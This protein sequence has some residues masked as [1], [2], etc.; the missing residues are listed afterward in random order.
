M[1]AARG[2]LSGA[3]LMQAQA[4]LWNHI[5]AY[6]RSMSL[7]CSV[8]LG[9]PDAVNRL[10]GVATVE[11]LV[12]NLGLPPSR[13]PYLR[14]LEHNGFF[15]FDDAAAGYGLTPLSRLLVSA[16]AAS[17]GGRTLAPFALAMLH[18]VIVSPSMS[19]AS[20]F[21]AADTDTA[22]ASVP[23]EA[24]HGR[25]LWAVAKGDREF[26]ASFNAAM[27]CDGRFVMD[28][29]VRDH[30]DVFRGLASLVDVGGGSG[31]AARA[32]A[33]TFPHVRCSVLE[34]P[35]VVASVP[36][37]EHRGVAF[38]AGDMFEHVPKAD[39]VLLK[40]RRTSLIL[41]HNIDSPREKKSEC[42][43]SDVL[44]LLRPCAVDLARVGRRAVRA[45]TAALQG[46]DPGEGSRR[47]GDRDGPG[48]GIEPGGREG[49]RDAAALGRD[50]DGG[51]REPRAGR[52]RVAQDL[53][54]RGLQ[55]PQDCRTPRDQIS[56]RGVPLTS[57]VPSTQ[58][59]HRQ[60]IVCFSA[61]ATLERLYGLY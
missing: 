7:R 21:R 6:T 56:N 29:L 24:F 45:D 34:L 36:P 59:E 43:K 15:A 13:A 55:R 14:L 27:A 40:V 23:F 31:G 30:G 16:P 41:H 35:H 20:W 57:C 10:G 25:D 58:A 1:G 17:G 22:A 42:V 26:G 52:A 51:G 33:A 2:D 8:E 53:R 39:A 32:I 37:G 9:I 38:V 49:H 46:G 60:I 5:F 54:G 44:R 4:E 18:P 19:L 11:D 28:V 61:T 12:G 50:D 3:E 47:Q 48:G